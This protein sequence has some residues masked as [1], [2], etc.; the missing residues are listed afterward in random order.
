MDT[1]LAATELAAMY[2]R[3][4]LDPC[5]VVEA[6]LARIGV[7]DADLNAFAVVD[8]EGARAAALSSAQRFSNGSPI[9]PLDGV[10]VTIKDIVA[11]AGFPV[12]SG[13]TT[14]ATAPCRDDAP[15]VARLREAGAVILGRTTTPEF[16]WKGMTD[17]PLTGV[18]RNPWDTRHT[19]GGSSG[20][21]AASL[22]A[23]IGTI[24][25]GTDGGGSIR[26]PASYCGLV[27][28]KPTFGRVPHHPQDSPFALSVAGG[29]IAR[30]VHD[31]ATFL[32]EVCKPDHRDP[33]AMPY[34][35]RDWRI[36]LD[37]GVRGLRVAATL[38]LGGAQIADADIATAW[39]ATLDALADLGA[40][41]IEVDD[42]FEPLRPQF[43]NHWK[44]GF[45]H[46]LRMVPRDR[47]S[48]CDPGFL[49][50]ARE[51]LDVPMSA[52]ADAMASRARL[53]TLLA[54]FHLTHD[55]LITPTMPTLAPRAD[56]IYHSPG[57]D[58]W[59]HA[60]PFTLPFNLTG[61]PAASMPVAL[62]GTGL[63]I[64]MQIV[65]ARFREDL[66]LRTCRAIES[67]G[68]PTGGFPMRPPGRFGQSV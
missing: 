65:A 67:A 17:S 41:I 3:R 37:D 15:S 56:V 28:V 55:V 34:D 44:A 59:D 1:H 7:L 53:I 30:T 5:E 25:F 6:H 32:N 54:T 58:R 35:A 21:A 49:E 27:G 16:G 57:F 31:A 14:S 22:A 68:R 52:F 45:A 26:I 13:S 42:V 39:R 33:W 66:V 36:G 24:A 18:T 8:A 4:K 12:G 63:P 29:P 19:P 9:G 46:L 62:S 40:E 11:M 48:E 51:G 47:W 50:L 60:V 20:G 38:T 23:G 61:Q 43:E 2:R 64:G 10:P